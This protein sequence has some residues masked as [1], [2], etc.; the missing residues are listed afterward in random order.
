MMRWN[1]L[2]VEVYCFDPTCDRSYEEH[3]EH[4][5]GS[6][7]EGHLGGFLASLGLW[8]ILRELCTAWREELY[9][10]LRWHLW[11]RWT[12][13]NEANMK[14]IEEHTLKEGECP[15]ADAWE[16]TCKCEFPEKEKRDEEG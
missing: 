16:D 14:W 2:L 11:R 8:R 9:S 5:Q 15:A 12:Y 7:C 13:D 4:R 6:W 3:L 1:Y 10:S